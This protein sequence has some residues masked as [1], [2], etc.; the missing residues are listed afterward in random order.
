MRPDE[1]L[2]RVCAEFAG[3]LRRNG[4]NQLRAF[5]VAIKVFER[6]CTDANIELHSAVWGVGRDLIAAAAGLSTFV[7]PQ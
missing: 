7:N 1:M 6:H 4:D 5:G 2:M 3:E